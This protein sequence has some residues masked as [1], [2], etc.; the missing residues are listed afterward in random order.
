MSRPSFFRRS[1]LITVM[2]TSSLAL[3]ACAANSTPGE[4]DDSPVAVTVWHTYSDAH[5][6]AYEEIVA[7]FNETQ[8]KVK[9]TA[10]PQPYSD[11]DSK[12]MQAV[13]NGNGPDIIVSS[14]SIA[15]Q[16]ID[17]GLVADLAPLVADPTNGVPNYAEDIVAGRQAGVTQWEDGAQYLYP[18]HSTGPVYFYNKTMFDELGLKAPTTWSELETVSRTL[19]G[20]TGAPAFGFD[21]LSYGVLTI[22][23]QQGQDFV[24]ADGTEATFDS[25]AYTTAIDWVGGLVDEGVFRLVGGDQYFSNPFG[26]GAVASYIG[27]SAGYPFV[28]MAVDGKFEVGVAPL[29]QE[30]PRKWAPEWGGDY[31]LFASDDRHEAAAFEFI[32]FFTSP[33]QLSRWDIALGAVPSSAAAQDEP[34]FQSFVKENAAITALSEQLPYVAVPNAA[35]GVNAVQAELATAI[36]QAITG[37]KSTKDALAEAA[38][39]SNALLK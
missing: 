24:N 12:V 39:A 19:T 29:P 11:F 16:Y 38:T 8:D 32:K 22:A 30:G 7:E 17:A 15:T 35:Q 36:E 2:L 31:L 28:E 5:A 27:A 13:R 3:S 23:N 26:A 18:L 14:P 25:P 9:V 1:A 20:N 33:E 34:A 37:Q 21:D 6:S 10:Q 4:K